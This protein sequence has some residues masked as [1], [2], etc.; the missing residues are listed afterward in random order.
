MPT[1]LPLGC[2]TLTWIPRDDRFLDG[3]NRA[4]MGESSVLPHFW[5][6]CCSYCLDYSQTDPASVIAE[7]T[8][9]IY[10][11][12]HHT[13]LGVLTV[14]QHSQELARDFFVTLNA[15]T[16]QTCS[17][18]RTVANTSRGFTTAS[19]AESA[20]FSDTSHRCLYSGACSRGS[21][22]EIVGVIDLRTRDTPTRGSRACQHD[23]E[24]TE[25]THLSRIE[26]RCDRCFSHSYI[27]VL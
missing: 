12:A 14:P 26:S 23:T 9:T 1:I 6:S 7:T 2:A 11:F 17:R 5:Q 15:A 21:A 10:R 13:T 22:G 20:S 24:L 4:W 18:A 16:E 19:V 27:H 8:E 25:L 3:V